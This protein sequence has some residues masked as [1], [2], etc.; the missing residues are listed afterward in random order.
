MARLRVLLLATAL[1][2]G[3]AWN[4]GPRDVYH[5]DVLESGESEHSSLVD[6]LKSLLR[7]LTPEHKSHVVTAKRRRADSSASTMS[8]WTESQLEKN[9]CQD[10]EPC[11]LGKGNMPGEEGCLLV[12]E[13]LVLGGTVDGAWHAHSACRT[14]VILCHLTFRRP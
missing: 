14:C 6:K 13:G 2:L 3:I 10:G 5:W 9:A 7:T 8:G 12:Q 11:Q 4:A 1:L